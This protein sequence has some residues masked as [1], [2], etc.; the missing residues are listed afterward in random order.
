MKSLL[1]SIYGLACATS[2]YAQVSPVAAQVAQ[3]S[4]YSGNEDVP[5]FWDN[6]FVGAGAGT[7]TYFG[8]HNRQMKFGETL[9]PHFNV[10]AGKW[11]TP[12]I[13]ARLGVSG[14]KIKGVTQNG[15][16]S[17][18]ERYSGK[19]WAGYFLTNQKFNYFHLHGDVLFN[20]SNLIWGVKEDR[21]YEAS[22]YVGVG[23]IVTNDKPK[24][25]EATANLGVL[26]TFRLNSTWSATFDV[27]STLVN[28][29]FDGEVGGHKNDGLLSATV[30]VVYKITKRALK[31]TAAVIPSYDDAVAENLQS[32]LEALYQENEVLRK[33]LAITKNDTITE[34]KTEVITEQRLLTAPVLITFAINS[35][36]LSKEARVNLGFFADVIKKSDPEAVY[37]II[38]YAD[39]STGRPETNERL[40]LARAKAVCDVLIQEYKID[41]NRLKIVGQ[42]GVD[43]MFYDDPSLN[44]AVISV[45]D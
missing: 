26:N 16:H 2:A 39:K 45:L 13:G 14:F 17:T 43:N 21:F 8:D 20:V 42:G 23:Y 28:D 30:G 6:W 33:Q 15:A 19:P 31:T 37:K 35:S 18:G 40:S 34:I 22:P 38:G 10:Y 7:Q 12:G 24:A 29:R 27:R 32:N 11:F 5:S 44:R 1:I 9:T 36:E 4:Q 41:A 3:T 25:R